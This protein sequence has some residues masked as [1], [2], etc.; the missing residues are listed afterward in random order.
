ME[1]IYELLG[2]L[3]EVQPSEMIDNSEK[4]FHAYLL[5]L[6][7]QVR[8][9]FAFGMEGWFLRSVD[10]DNYCLYYDA[11]FNGLFQFIVSNWIDIFPCVL[12]RYM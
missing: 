5:E 1:R 9:G 12:L 6:K 3:G 2:V 8:K 7:V 11:G 10:N 4:L